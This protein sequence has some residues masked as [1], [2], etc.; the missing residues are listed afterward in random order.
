MAMVTNLKGRLRNT[1]LP[2]THGLSPLFEA[3]V[4]SIH[5][6]E[7][8]NG[9]IDDG[10]IAVEILRDPQETLKLESEDKKKGPDAV[11]KIAGFRIVDNGDGFTDANMTSFETLD[12]D[13]KIDKG[14]R[15]IGRLLWL[16]AFD[17]VDVLSRFKDSSGELWARSFVFNSSE[18]VS[19][20]KTYRPEVSTDVETTVSLMGFKPDYRDSSIKTTSAIATSLFEHCLWYFIR[21]GG[22]P[23]ITVSDSDETVDLD[24]VYDEHM[25]SSSD[26]EQI[27]LKDQQFELTHVKL[28]SHSSQ[29]HTLAYCASNRL[30]KEETING[31]V[32][33]LFGKI[34][35]D[36]DQFVYACYI[37]SEYLDSAVRTERTGFDFGDGSASLFADIELTSDEIRQA[38]LDRVK[39]FLDSYLEHNKK[40]GRERVEKFVAESA[41]RYRPILSRIP[42]DELSVD[43]TIS[44]RDLELKLHRQLNDIEC[45]LMTEG[46]EILNPKADE[47][48]EQY[49]SRVATYLEK[50]TDIKKSDLAGYV[51]HRRVVIDLLTTAIAKDETGNYVREDLIHDLIM[52]MGKDS[53]EV[54]FEDSNLWLIDERLAFHD[55]L[56]SDK[57]LRSQPITGST[58][59][60]EPDIA[61]LN[62]FDNPILVSETSQL[63][64]A[65]IVVVEIKRPMRNDAATG[66]DK[67]PIEQALGYLERIREG[68]VQ[69]PGG[70]PI[71]HSEDI[72]GFCYIL[73]DLTPAVVKRCKVHDGIRTADGLGYFL[74]NKTYKAYVQVISFDQLV[75]AATQRNRAFF[76]KLGLPAGD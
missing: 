50:V 73:C 71:P 18:G 53:S 29:A 8:Q 66:E 70:R 1:S 61:I 11:A 46:H 72:P 43:P 57:T 37:G 40:I 34:E 5:S 68:R 25:I 15:G 41:P 39:V 38:I 26:H 30:V 13:L 24:V 62:K 45:G 10:T 48:V 76:D 27:T 3:V 32:P 16:K 21:D 63:P 58:S 51:S 9:G 19:N 4:N 44:D 56:A 54:F 65:S 36:D 20:Q 75:N 22:A 74:Y 28:R 69:T 67:D 49:R 60:K 7:D 33:G 12:S 55:Y 52:P 31:K 64:L 47:S 35:S 59:T 42:E 6:I 14:C 23:K 17:R 2:K